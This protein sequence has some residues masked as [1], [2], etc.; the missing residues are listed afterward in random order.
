MNVKD[1]LKQF[2]RTGHGNSISATFEFENGGEVVVDD[3][4]ANYVPF[5][6]Q[7]HADNGRGDGNQG[8]WMDE[9]ALDALRKIAKGLRDIVRARVNALEGGV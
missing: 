2:P 6:V 8:W 1:F 9:D 5:K 4:G 7:M 3:D